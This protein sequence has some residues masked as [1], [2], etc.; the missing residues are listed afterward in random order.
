MRI[1]KSEL[2]QIIKEELQSVVEG[3]APN[4]GHSESDAAAELATALEQS[5]AVMNGVQQLLEDPEI[6]TALQAALQEEPIEETYDR[7]EQDFATG[8]ATTVGGSALA[9][10]SLAAT[11]PTSAFAMKFLPFLAANPITANLGLVGGI[12]LTALG[13]LIAKEGIKNRVIGP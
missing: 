8:M 1:T 2:K 7:S 11:S 4:Q 9:L 3:G 13:L 10:A 6:V 5:D 12:D